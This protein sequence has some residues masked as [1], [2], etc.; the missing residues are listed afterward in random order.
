M[1]RIYVKIYALHYRTHTCDQRYVH[2]FSAI[3]F[4][5]KEDRVDCVAFFNSIIMITPNELQH[6]L[7]VNALQSVSKN[8]YHPPAKMAAIAASQSHC[9]RPSSVPGCFEHRGFSVSTKNQLSPVNSDNLSLYSK[10]SP[11]YQLSLSPTTIT[12]NEEHI[13]PSLRGSALNDETSQKD[14][15][16]A[17]SPQSTL[18]IQYSSGEDCM[19]PFHYSNSPHL[20]NPSSSDSSPNSNEHNKK[21][22]AVDKSNNDSNTTSNNKGSELA[23]FDFPKLCTKSDGGFALN[24]PTDV[25]L[26]EDNK[27]QSVWNY[28]QRLMDVIITVVN[29]SGKI[30][31]YDKNLPS[32][33][34]FCLD[35]N[36]NDS[37][38]ANLQTGDS[39]TSRIQDGDLA[40]WEKHTSRIFNE[41]SRWSHA[42]NALL[43]QSLLPINN[44]DGEVGNQQHKKIESSN[45]NSLIP[46]ENSSNR[47]L[48]DCPIYRVKLGQKWFYV[49]TFSL[50][51]NRCTNSSLL[52]SDMSLYEPLVVHY[53]NLLRGYDQIVEST[54]SN[55]SIC[56]KKAIAQ[57]TLSM[58]L[59]ETNCSNSFKNTVVI[60]SSSVCEN[61]ISSH[62]IMSTA[63]DHCR[64]DEPS[65]GSSKNPLSTGTCLSYIGSPDPSVTDGQKLVFNSTS[66]PPSSSL[67]LPHH[68]HVHLTHCHHHHP[69]EIH[70]GTAVTSTT[71]N[72]HHH[73][74]YVRHH[75]TPNA[76]HN[77][78]QPVIVSHLP[79]QNS[80]GEKST[81]SSDT[82]HRLMLNQRKINIDNVGC[83]S[84]V[85]HKDS[86]NDNSLTCQT[87]T[88]HDYQS[89]L[90]PSHH[91]HHLH[92]HHHHHHHPHIHTG[93]NLHSNDY[94]PYCH[95]NDK[96]T[97]TEFVPTSSS[98]TIKSD[99][100]SKSP[101]LVVRKSS[102]QS[103]S[104][105]SSTTDNNTLQYGNTNVIGTYCDNNS[106]LSDIS[107]DPMYEHFDTAFIPNSCNE[108]F[109][110][111]SNTYHY[112][113]N[114]NHSNNSA[115]VYSTGNISESLS[116][117]SFTNTRLP[118]NNA[119]NSATENVNDVFSFIENSN[120][121]LHNVLKNTTTTT[122][123]TN[124]QLIHENH[125]NDSCS[126]QQRSLN[127]D[128]YDRRI[129]MLQ[130]LLP[131]QAIQEIRQI[132]QEM[133]RLIK[134]DSEISR[135][136]LKSSASTIPVTT[137]TTTTEISNSSPHNVSNV[138]RE[139][140][141]RRVRQV[142]R[143]YLGPKAFITDNLPEP[144][145]EIDSCFKT[146]D[147][148]MLQS[149][150][151][152][153]LGLSTLDYD[154][155]GKNSA[156]NSVINVIE[157]TDPS[158]TRPFI[159]STITTIPSTKSLCA[160]V[161]S[162]DT[163][164]STIGMFS[165]EITNKL[166]HSE[167]NI[168]ESNSGVLCPNVTAT[169][170]TSSN[171]SDTGNTVQKI[172][173]SCNETVSNSP[174]S[175][176][177]KQT[178]ELIVSQP[179]NNNNKNNINNSVSIETPYT[180]STGNLP[181]VSTNSQC[182]MLEW[183][184]SE[185]ADLCIL[186][187][188]LCQSK[189]GDKPQQQSISGI[190]PPSSSS[191]HSQVISPRASCC[192]A[193]SSQT[194]NFQ[195]GSP[196]LTEVAYS[197]ISMSQQK[198]NSELQINNRSLIPSS[199]SGSL[200][201]TT[202]VGAGTVTSSVN[203]SYVEIRSLQPRTE[204]LLVRLLHPAKNQSVGHHTDMNT[205]DG[206]H[207]LK[208][209]SPTLPRSVAVT[210]QLVPDTTDFNTSNI[211]TNTESEINN[212]QRQLN[213][214]KS[215]CRLIAVSLDNLC[216][217]QPT[218]NTSKRCRSGPATTQSI[219]SPF[220]PHI[221]PGNK[222]TR[223][224]SQFE[225][226]PSPSIRKIFGISDAQHNSDVIPSPPFTSLTQL[227]LQDFP[228][229]SDI[230]SYSS[231]D[232]PKYTPL[233][234]QNDYHC[235]STKSFSNTVA[236]GYENLQCNMTTSHDQNKI[237]SSN[238]S[239]SD[240]CH[241]INPPSMITS[242]KCT[243][244][245]GLFI[246]SNNVTFSK[247]ISSFDH[248]SNDE[249][250]LSTFSWSTLSPN[251]N[252]KSKLENKDKYLVK[253]SKDSE[254]NSTS[255]LIPGQSS[256]CQLLLDAQLEPEEISDAVANVEN[257]S[258]LSFNNNTFSTINKCKE[259]RNN[260]DMSSFKINL[261][262]TSI[263]DDNQSFSRL[264]ASTT[265]TS[266]CG[267][268][269]STGPTNSCS[270][271]LPPPPSSYSIAPV[272]WNDDDLQ[273][274]IHE[275]ITNPN[276]ALLEENNRN[277]SSSCSSSL[278]LPKRHP[279]T[280]SK[281]ISEEVE[282]LCEILRRD[283]LERNNEK[284]EYCHPNQ[285]DTT[286]AVTTTSTINTPIITGTE[287]G[288]NNSLPYLS[289]S[290]SSKRSR[291]SSS[292]SIS[293]HQVD[294]VG[295]N[296]ASV[297]GDFVHRDEVNWQNDAKAV[298]RICEQLQQGLVT[299]K[300]PVT[301]SN[302]DS[303]NGAVTE[304][305]GYSVKINDHN[306]SSTPALSGNTPD[307][308]IPRNDIIVSLKHVSPA[309]DPAMTNLMTTTCTTWSGY[310]PQTTSGIGHTVLRRHN[311]GNSSISGSSSSS[312]ITTTT[313][314][315]NV[316]N[317][318]AVAAALASQQAAASQ[319]NQ[320]T[321][322]RLLA[323]QRK[324]LIQHQLYNQV[325]VYSLNSSA[326]SR[327]PM[328][329][330]DSNPPV[331]TFFV[332]ENTYGIQN[333]PS[334][335]ISSTITNN[336]T[337]I[338][339]TTTTSHNDHNQTYH[340]LHVI[341]NK[342]I[343]RKS[344]SLDTN[345]NTQNMN[346]SLLNLNATTVISSNPP[347]FSSTSKSGNFYHY[348]HHHRPEDLSRFLKEVGPNVQVQLSC[349]IPTIDNHQLS[350]THKTPYVNPALHHRNT[351]KM[352][353]PS[354]KHQLIAKTTPITP[355]T[356]SSTSSM[357]HN[358]QTSALQS[359]SIGSL[360]SS[361]SSRKTSS[362]S[363]VYGPHSSTVSN[364]SSVNNPNKISR[365]D[366][367]VLSQ[368]HFPFVDNN[369]SCLFKTELHQG[370]VDLQGIHQNDSVVPATTTIITTDNN[371]S[372]FKCS[373]VSN[374]FSDDSLP[375][376]TYQAC[377]STEV[378]QSSPAATSSVSSLSYVSRVP[379]SS[380]MA[381][382]ESAYSN[383]SCIE[384]PMDSV[385]FPEWSLPQPVFVQHQKVNSDFDNI[386]LCNNTV[387]P[388]SVHLAHSYRSQVF[389][390]KT[391]NNHKIDTSNYLTRNDSSYCNNNN[392]LMINH[393]N[394]VYPL[395]PCNSLS[396]ISV[397]ANTSPSSSTT[398]GY[399]KSPPPPLPPS[400][401][402]QSIELPYSKSSSSLDTLVNNYYEINSTNGSF[403]CCFNNYS[404]YPTFHRNLST[405]SNSST[406]SYN[407]NHTSQ[408]TPVTTII[409]PHLESMLQSNYKH[410]YQQQNEENLLPDDLIND[411]F[412]LEIMIA[413]KQQREYHHHNST[414]NELRYL[415]VDTPPVTN[416]QQQ[417][418][419]QLNNSNVE[420]STSS[421]R[422]SS[423]SILNA[424]NECSTTTN[425]FGAAVIVVVTR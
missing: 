3:N 169:C 118:Q 401:C 339:T 185:E 6:S 208:L 45:S 135:M 176:C 47:H 268:L 61:P 120:E 368:K 224:A 366:S 162:G 416:K 12:C 199:N 269:S 332:N 55:A 292:T 231:V 421:S 24:L 334:L 122:T 2:D 409:D 139:N 48:F 136:S 41:A 312:V 239:Q 126:V 414:T 254:N 322:Q 178:D 232:S 314:I 327:N 397:S 276:D 221:S 99:N 424:T 130:H 147:I 331:N 259:E 419:P 359:S 285:C 29:R 296:K 177:I 25:I 263:A 131:P 95:Q 230:I 164:S 148:V 250:T 387:Y 142:V 137:T 422:L 304:F 90:D 210:S 155:N 316:V 288:N 423:P 8:L 75:H 198:I 175:S 353:R 272:E 375:T 145:S 262:F 267:G 152:Q 36:D 225:E 42:R 227:L 237:I 109:H 15:V 352:Q 102:S 309:Q 23:P 140:F 66:S 114:S 335:N 212:V 209:S 323:E 350:N 386:S 405:T 228:L 79:H 111:R 256:I 286:T 297:D 407:Y 291:F 349:S 196:V 20:R 103:H 34:S 378:D 138:V 88:D 347:S 217:N 383:I 376:T 260:V 380:L 348:Y 195:Y 369:N 241:S 311:S 50:P 166:F 412:D 213:N 4:G 271:I 85:Y 229:V 255:S 370:L 181:R 191:L 277:T 379:S 159:L 264:L 97:I 204:S 403:D 402:Q 358:S 32:Q 306:N 298:A 83:S 203:L 96:S 51:I 377:S 287:A 188:S 133:N 243:R 355:T 44:D 168:V 30:L 235:K 11:I 330:T 117:L 392:T 266:S 344:L 91:H 171:I 67:V 160:S 413:T 43:E 119:I 127:K 234:G 399:L 71:N 290:P 86:T 180:S 202:T 52:Q 381:H 299:E 223:H 157:G 150:N 101:I 317:K 197:P 5:V 161:G 56:L 59:T 245:Q 149:D 420:L 301:S 72:H 218:T 187:P 173:T 338:S 305:P 106:L 121:D 373:Q 163:T 92:H 31:Y 367:I 9:T 124:R 294:T 251:S 54:G 279:S 372:S 361:L 87:I 396:P 206:G 240:H 28:H 242:E 351:V 215:E 356:P 394:I 26:P 329:N 184:L 105:H 193:P 385:H 151:S 13:S 384:S 38:Y 129:L 363:P 33:H 46:S 10:I 320:L 258:N 302:N 284:N 37:N 82:S 58:D 143:Q 390:N 216:N 340:L 110:S 354:A 134:G 270:S 19:P 252:V 289:E 253:T 275:A 112:N 249:N 233:F 417:Q 27:G 183:L 389:P 293:D 325:A 78:P 39:W 186:P 214:R 248:Q 104:E 17:N 108:E 346:V 410:Q 406:I 190:S 324:R 146:D 319:R 404:S 22:N 328:S 35:N 107:G 393:S 257:Y 192:M 415:T 7:D 398:S 382:N 307:Y 125:Q 132:W 273:Q 69:N 278:D 300:L 63:N 62:L 333:L 100:I 64:I 80:I 49:H 89:H 68:H 315:T 365:E 165:S 308:S 226:V 40:I 411:V 418:Q 60:P 425:T 144:R 57:S 343:N 70:D 371:H 388:Q 222:R 220:S 84:S 128:Q 326:N 321:N 65:N 53:H 200:I 73:H 141:A 21:H 408:D 374:K 337:I 115:V 116:D 167:T 194:H 244:S 189:V 207:L 156:S 341:P 280:S 174:L 172:S 77:S 182:C 282:I 236:Q 261:Q 395:T 18:V 76:S 81:W 342:S 238:I 211:I 391:N 247:H 205:S 274:L 318:A 265:S 74:H 303:N 170:V 295:D 219:S 93:K 113:C 357:F 98:S 336:N 345:T 179:L 313:T 400:A 283:E 123:T 360:S 364:L 281:E 362:T 94:H 201:T 1:H 246:N 16:P 310:S 158:F 154:E 153:E 14:Y